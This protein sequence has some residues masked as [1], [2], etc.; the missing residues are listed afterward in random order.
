MGKQKVLFINIEFYISICH[1]SFISDI[2]YNI[3]FFCGELMK[4][5]IN[6]ENKS[7]G[8]TNVFKVKSE[9]E[10]QEHQR[11]GM[12]IGGAFLGQTCLMSSE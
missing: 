10:G 1:S 5:G 11:C 2:P 3:E 6:M 8:W 4:R 9:V 7:K 12:I